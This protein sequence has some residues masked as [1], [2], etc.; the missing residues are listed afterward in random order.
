MG[1]SPPTPSFSPSVFC[2]QFPLQLEQMRKRR[3]W[4]CVFLARHV[5]NDMLG[6]VVIVKAYSSTDQC[7]SRK[8]TQ[9]ILLLLFIQKGRSKAMLGDNLAIYFHFILTDS[10]LEK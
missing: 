1:P 2:F 3:H 4:F 6:S 7:Y 5:F 9:N 8:M 10:I